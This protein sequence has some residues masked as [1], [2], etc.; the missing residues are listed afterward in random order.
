[1]LRI[2]YSA[3]VVGKDGEHIGVPF[4][5]EGGMSLPTYDVVK[6]VLAT[7]PGSHIIIT[8]RMVD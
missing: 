1:M 3:Q 6:A 5:D 7:H 4:G 8:V 2:R